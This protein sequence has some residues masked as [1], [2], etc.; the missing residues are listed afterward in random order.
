MLF[1]SRGSTDVAN[2]LA[3]AARLPSDFSSDAATGSLDPSAGSAALPSD[4]SRSAARDAALFA[5]SR[6]LFR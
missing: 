3:L 2:P 1:R 5:S 4:F 6:L